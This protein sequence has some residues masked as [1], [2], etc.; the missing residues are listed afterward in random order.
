MS[1]R[2][3]LSGMALIGEQ[4]REQ[5]QALL[6]A[7]EPSR[8]MREEMRRIEEEFRTMRPYLV[9][10]PIGADV[11]G[12]ADLLT[13]RADITGLYDAGLLLPPARPA[14]AASERQEPKPLIKPT[15]PADLLSMLEQALAADKKVAKQALALIAK[16]TGADE[17]ALRAELLEL[18]EYERKW[19]KKK[20]NVTPEAFVKRERNKSRAE[21]YRLLD[22]L[23]E[24]RLLLSALS[25][26]E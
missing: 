2:E 14:P 6:A 7:L 20:G 13:A 4:I 1:D 8:V 24:V 19:F 26:P 9:L 18:E 17:A 11:T 25:D 3:K 10:P 23:K 16:H 15:A 22:R 21:H 12:M 5:Q